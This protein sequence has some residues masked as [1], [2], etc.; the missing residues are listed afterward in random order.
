MALPFGTAGE[1]RITS[2]YSYGQTV[3]RLDTRED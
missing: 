2:S 1:V 3:G